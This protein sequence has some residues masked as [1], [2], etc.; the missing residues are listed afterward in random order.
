MTESEPA[1]KF[2]IAVVARIK[3]GALYEA[4]KQRGWKMKQAA[5]FL[6]VPHSSLCSAI[7]LKRKMPYLFPQKKDK[8]SRNRARKVAEKLMELTG[9]SVEDLF[10]KEFRTKKFLALPKVGERFADVPT[11]LLLEQTGM[12]ALPLSPDEALIEKEEGFESQ[13]QEL[14]D[15]LSRLSDEA[16]HDV[17]QFVLAGR[18]A[19]EVAVERGVSAKAVWANVKTAITEIRRRVQAR[20]RREECGQ[21]IRSLGKEAST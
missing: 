4:I 2:R 5:E 12:L 9:K 7:N 18:P 8:Q 17:K 13:E 16:Q 6:G 11:R 3:H 10:P 19:R 14:L 15:I 21:L 20:R 1:D